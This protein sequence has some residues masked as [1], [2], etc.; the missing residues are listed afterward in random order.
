MFLPPSELQWILRYPLF[1][2]VRRPG[3]GGA[4][5]GAIAGRPLGAFIGGG[6]PARAF[7]MS[8]ADRSETSSALRDSF[9]R[10]PRAESLLMLAAALALV[11]A[12]SPLGHVYHD[13]LHAPT[14]P[15]LSREARADDAASVDQ[16]RADGA[17]L[18]ARRAGDQARVRRRPARQ[19]GPAAAPVPRRRVR[20][21]SCR[22]SIYLVARRR[23]SGSSAAGRSRPRPTSP[24]RSACSRCSAAA[25]RPR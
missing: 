12:N 9:G 8:R 10:R 11:V 23:R 1:W 21:W 2:V 6:S 13:L 19:L 17:V 3:D 20:A 5:E 14:G 24:S 18:P 16:R 22:R 15:V 7:V 25:R 4:A